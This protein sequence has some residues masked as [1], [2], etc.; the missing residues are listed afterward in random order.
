M[1]KKKKKQQESIR[2]V[3]VRDYSKP[4]NSIL[5]GLLNQYLRMNNFAATVVEMEEMSLLVC[6]NIDSLKKIQ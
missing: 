6:R 2:L 4:I 3:C 1:W 5:L